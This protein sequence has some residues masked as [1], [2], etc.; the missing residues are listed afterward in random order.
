MSAVAEPLQHAF[1][2][3]LARRNALVLSVAQALAGG[4]NTVIVSTASIVGAVLAPDKGLATLPVTAMVFG[5]WL[6]TLPVGVLA[7]RFGRRFALQ[8]GSAFGILSGLISYSAVVNAHFWL[9]L[10]GTFCGGLYAAAHQS[11][12]FAAADTASDAYRPKVVSWVLAGGIF[13]AVL[14]PQLVIFTKDLLPPYLFAA[15]YLGQS[16]C[17]LLAAF[18]LQFV[19]VPPLSK[20]YSGSA[21]PLAEIVRNSRFI[22][23]V[24]CGI[25]SYGMMNML[26]TSAPLAMVGCGHSVTDAALGIQWHVLAMYAPSFVTGSL[27]ARFGVER[28]TGVGLLLIAAAAVVGIAG[29]SVAHFWTALVLLGFGWNL[30]FIGATTMVTQCHRPHER[31]KVQAFNDFLIFGSMALA[32]FSS[33]QLLEKFGWVTINEVIFPS[34][35][36]AGALLLWLALRPRESTV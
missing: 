8:C 1:D 22:V 34:I 23:A 19:K 20:P 24:A 17:A 16:I 36:V 13:A 12:R 25:A 21:R 10:V 33:G 5:M 31:N 28:I 15:S 35:F 30:S 26:M 32:S 4:N 3:D 14:G 29:I 7:R 27:I 18:V 11:Y 2:D 9:L 6:G